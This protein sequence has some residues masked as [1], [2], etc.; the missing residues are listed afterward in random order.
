MPWPLAFVLT[1]FAPLAAINYYVGKRLLDAIV[2]VFRQ[3]RQKVRWI[4]T[5]TLVYLNLLPVVFLISY[6]LQG[7][8]SAV[9]FSGEILL[10]DLLLTYP[11]WIALIITVQLFLLFALMEG[12][13]LLLFP[14]YKSHKVRWLARERYI[15]IVASGVVTLYSLITIF[16]DTWLIRVTEHTVKLPAQYSALDGVKIAQISD[17]KGDARTT[18]RKLNDFVEKVNALQPDLILF[19]GDV[20]TS[21]TKYI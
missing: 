19:A 10:V 16:A 5:L 17:V 18:E 12:F 4:L 11:F 14:L 2:E 1:I 8:T 7:R 15:L 13:K 21:G 20:I 9:A 6:L 3:P